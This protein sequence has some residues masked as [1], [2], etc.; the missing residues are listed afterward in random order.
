[1]KKFQNLVNIS[2]A[3]VS[4]PSDKMFN[5]YWV[6]GCSFAIFNML[7]IFFN[8]MTQFALKSLTVSYSVSKTLLR[9]KIES[10]H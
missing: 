3:H 7:V 9:R 2:K 4:G 1:M 6:T 10:H 5:V 8:H